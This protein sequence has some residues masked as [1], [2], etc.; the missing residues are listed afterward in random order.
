MEDPGFGSI[1]VAASMPAKWIADSLGLNLTGPSFRDP[2]FFKLGV[3]LAQ[4]FPAKGA[5]C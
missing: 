5:D 4:E 2:A 1:T 3:A